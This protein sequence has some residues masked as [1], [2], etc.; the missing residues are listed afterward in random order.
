MGKYEICDISTARVDKET[1]AWDPSAPT[2]LIFEA[3][4]TR[5]IYRFRDGTVK[6]ECVLHCF[7]PSGKQIG[8]EMDP[9][10]VKDAVENLKSTG[11]WDAN[12]FE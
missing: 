11:V 9:D 4:V 6:G 10:S 8:F 1:L 3:G 5:R 2:C 7:D 12:G